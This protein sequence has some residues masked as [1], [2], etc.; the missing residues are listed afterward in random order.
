[1]LRA[2]S[3]KAQYPVMDNY[4]YATT[5]PIYISVAGQK[6]RAPEDAKYFAAWIARTGE[7][8]AAYPDWNSPQE[9]ELV[10]RRL[11]E[12]KQIYEK[13]E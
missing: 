10:L 13:M 9:K 4:A 12:A 7:I 1:V 5:S 11:N 8:T 6:Q 3:D 2:W